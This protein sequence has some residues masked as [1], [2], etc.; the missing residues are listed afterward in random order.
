MI[1]ERIN[2]MFYKDGRLV[3]LTEEELKAYAESLMVGDMH[4]PERHTTSKLAPYGTFTRKAGHTRTT[5]EINSIGVVEVTV[6]Y[7]V[8]ESPFKSSESGRVMMF[9]SFSPTQ[10]KAHNVSSGRRETER[11]EAWG[12]NTENERRNRM[13][14]I[15]RMRCS[16]H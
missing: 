15:A 6:Y 9:D 4:Q 14:A 11:R 2:T 5:V 12:Y 16:K 7:R 3:A 1:Y 10:R 8:D 13:A